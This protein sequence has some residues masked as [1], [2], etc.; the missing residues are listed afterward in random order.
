M[1]KPPSQQA[2]VAYLNN[3]KNSFEKIVC[4]Y[5]GRSAMIALGLYA[6]SDKDKAIKNALIASGVIEFYLFYYYSKK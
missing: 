4:T 1:N 6:F 2:I 5:L 3:E